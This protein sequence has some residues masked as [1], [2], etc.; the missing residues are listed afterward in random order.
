M[1][2]FNVQWT[3]LVNGEPS[4]VLCIINIFEKYALIK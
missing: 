1:F 3:G 4:H 2:W